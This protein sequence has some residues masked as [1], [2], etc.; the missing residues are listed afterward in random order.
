LAVPDDLLAQAGQLA[1]REPKRPQQAGLRRAVST[2]YYALFHLLVEAGA[3]AMAPAR[4]RPL[5]DQVRRAFTHG[6]MKSVCKQFQA[7]NIANLSARL[8]ALV[9]T[10]LEAEFLVVAAAFVELQDARH[11]ADYDFSVPFTRA[12]VLERLDLTERAFQAWR[13]L[14][15]KP[16]ANVFLAALLLNRN[17]G[18]AGVSEST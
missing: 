12:D 14:R 6:D 8:Q 18:R 11:S 13:V 16:N 15:D 5:R 3:R 9:Q 17:W 1:R 10:P 7:G 4:P 2:A